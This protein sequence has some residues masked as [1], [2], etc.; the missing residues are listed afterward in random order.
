MSTA[1]TGV[2]T[3]NSEPTG[4]TALNTS[5]QAEPLHNIGPYEG[6]KPLSTT[7]T[8]TSTSK[9]SS[10]QS[11]EVEELLE[12]LGHPKSLVEILMN[13][14]VDTRE[15]LLLLLREEV[16]TVRSKLGLGIWE[17]DQ[18]RARQLGTDKTLATG[19]TNP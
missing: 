10:C 17:E 8:I 2:M 14:R 19:D 7:L 1:L 11:S 6:S 15:D 13:K 3:L 5:E 4:V 9:P 16:R 12:K 18:E